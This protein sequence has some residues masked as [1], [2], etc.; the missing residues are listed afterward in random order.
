MTKS[1]NRMA[2]AMLLCFVIGRWHQFAKSGFK[3]DPMDAWPVQ[4]PY[5]RPR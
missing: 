4:W 5:L 3:R 2:L 1:L